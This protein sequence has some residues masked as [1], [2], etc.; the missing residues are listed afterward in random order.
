[1]GGHERSHCVVELSPARH[2]LESRQLRAFNI[3]EV[4]RVCVIRSGYDQGGVMVLGREGTVS[5]Y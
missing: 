3:N 4:E 1:M 5:V 2:L